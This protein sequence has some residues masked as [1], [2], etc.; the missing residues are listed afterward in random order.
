MITFEESEEAMLAESILK[1]KGLRVCFTTPP[2]GCG[3]AI[4]ID[5][6]NKVMMDQILKEQNIKYEK[7]IEAYNKNE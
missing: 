7:I 5:L 4:E 1:K 2:K 3:L 6:D